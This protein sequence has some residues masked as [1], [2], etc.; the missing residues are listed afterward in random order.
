MGIGFSL[1]KSA[2]RVSLGK[3]NTEA[4]IMEF[5]KILKSFVMKGK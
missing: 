5:T 3:M 4:E 2:I 1:A